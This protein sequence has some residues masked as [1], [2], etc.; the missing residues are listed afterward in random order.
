M[1]AILVLFTSV[2]AIP[3][4]ASTYDC[5]AIYETIDANQKSIEEQAPM[6]KSFEDADSI[7]Y[8]ADLEGKSFS[9][10]LDK[11][12]LDA[13]IQITTA[14]DYTKGSVTHAHPDAQGR[15]SLAEVNG[16]TVH[17]IVC[18]RH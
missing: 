11:A 10:V 16:V 14:P 2:C 7:R 17:K 4:W 8:E 15:I 5:S 6:P 12:S 1:K 13:L 18:F 3:V 9:V